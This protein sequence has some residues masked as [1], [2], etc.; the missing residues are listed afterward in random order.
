ME[1]RSKATVMYYFI[2]IKMFKIRNNNNLTAPNDK[3]EKQQGFVLIAGGSVKW[4]G[5]FR[6]L[7]NNNHTP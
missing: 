4:Y 6:S 1:T 7:C 5:H 3:K 2:S